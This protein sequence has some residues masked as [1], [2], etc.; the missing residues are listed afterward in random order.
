MAEGSVISP[1]RSKN[2]TA[3]V[4]KYY[5]ARKYEEILTKGVPSPHPWWKNV[6]VFT[7]DSL[8]ALVDSWKEKEEVARLIEKAQ[9]SPVVGKY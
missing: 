2:F 3:D 5:L 1:K 8:K 7:P 4:V 9:K 6:P